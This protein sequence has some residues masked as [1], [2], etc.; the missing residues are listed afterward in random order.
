MASAG[1]K[2][3]MRREK[4]LELLDR[5][6]KVRVAQL[7]REFGTTPVTIRNDLDALEQS[8]CLERVQ[9][10]AIPKNRMLPQP[11]ADAHLQEKQ[12]IAA[13]AAA[14]I[15]DGDTLFI[16]SG[17]TTQKVAVALKKHRNLNVVTNS[18][19]VAS[20]LSG[21]PTFRVILLGGVLNAQYA[22]TC[23][24][25][26]QE[27][28]QRYQADSAI[29]SLDGISAEAGISTYHADEAI[30]DRLM[31]ERAQKV[32]IVADHS[33]MGHAGFSFVA[34]LQRVHTVVTDAGCDPA[35]LEEIRA[36]QVRVVLA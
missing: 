22:F 9:G 3:N 24:G 35:S 15:H 32:F 17:V 14:L 23:G 16:N 34:P 6:G 1:L 4:I 29:L 31:V 36:A 33:K 5:D 19:A 27:Q 26:A 30:I 25:D 21:I 13:A 10:G 11:S 28:L 20:E 7:S 2:I 12:V 8:G 18:I